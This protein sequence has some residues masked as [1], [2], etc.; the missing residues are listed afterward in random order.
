[1]AKDEMDQITED[2]WDQDIWG[3]EH[4]DVEHKFKVPKLVFYFGENV[5]YALD[6]GW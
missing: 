3:V 5:G 2:R 1:M 6:F 4:E